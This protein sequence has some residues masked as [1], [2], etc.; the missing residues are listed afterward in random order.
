MSDVVHSKKSVKA[1]QRGRR[2]RRRQFR[3]LKA[4]VTV[5]LLKSSPSRVLIVT[6]LDKPN[7]LQIQKRQRIRGEK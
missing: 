1:E 7:K 4:N 2:R 5:K 3:R 6:N